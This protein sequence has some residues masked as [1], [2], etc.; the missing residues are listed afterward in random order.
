MLSDEETENIVFESEQEFNNTLEV[1]EI[2]LLKSR[3]KIG[4]IAPSGLQYLDTH[5]KIFFLPQKNIFKVE[6]SGGFKD[7]LCFKNKKDAYKYFNT[8]VVKNSLI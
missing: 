5:I 8:G 3:T 2:L 1:E 6:Y 7:V 4:E